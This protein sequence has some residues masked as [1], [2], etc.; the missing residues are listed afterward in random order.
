VSLKLALAVVAAVSLL[1]EVDWH[2]AAMA[3]PAVLADLARS[4][5]P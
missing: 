1:A 4:L 5:L 3:E 2:W